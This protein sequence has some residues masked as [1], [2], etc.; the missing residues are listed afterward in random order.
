[1]VRGTFSPARA[2]RPAVSYRLARTLGVANTIHAMPST[3]DLLYSECDSG[4]AHC[5]LRDLRALT[6]HHL[7]QS[8]PKNEDYDNKLVLCHNCH[9]CHHE[10][11]GPSAEQLRDIKRRLI[12]KT[13]T[14]PGLNALKLANRRGQV[15]AMPFLVTHLIEQQYLQ[16]KESV[17]TWLRDGQKPED[18][19]D[20]TAVYTITERGKKMLEKW[21]LK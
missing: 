8:K 20:N 14:I 17:V 1:V 18:F 12:V 13:L 2:W 10:G 6:I 16:Y 5:G 19:A 11:K 9:Q 7:E 21:A 15:V 4:C 3:D